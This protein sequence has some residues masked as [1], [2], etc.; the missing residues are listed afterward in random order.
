MKEEHTLQGKGVWRVSAKKSEH[1]QRA[2][3]VDADGFLNKEQLQF[4]KHGPFSCCFLG[5][6]KKERCGKVCPYSF[7]KTS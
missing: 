1:V 4:Y 6:D 5:G 3:K 2:K 7:S